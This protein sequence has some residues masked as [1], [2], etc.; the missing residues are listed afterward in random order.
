MR[1]RWLVLLC[2]ATI[3]AIV[4]VF[5]FIRLQPIKPK[6]DLTAT[7]KAGS[8][9]EPSVTFV[10]PSKGA[11]NAKVTIIEFSDFQCD[12]CKQLAKTLDVVLRT[13]PN[14]LRVV[15]KDLPNES[16]HPLATLTAIAAH[17]ANDQ[18]KF[19]EYHDLVFDRQN[20]LSEDELVRIAKDAGL[21][22]DAFQKCY[23]A[24]D[25]LGIVKKDY[26]EGVALEIV[27]TPT[28]FINGTRIIGAVEVEQLTA[29]VR[30]QLENA[31]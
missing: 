20:F 17:C 21:N 11:S 13:F 10:N 24:R 30:A 7:S 8:L 26:D 5:F 3:T 28:M 2:F 31:K 12:A 15:W 14:D 27:A 19:W 6:V 4:F 16:T 25:T 22:T 18:G 23:D 9:S 1:N 29:E